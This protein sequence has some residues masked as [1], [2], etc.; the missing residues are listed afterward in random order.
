MNYGALKTLANQYLEVDETTF[1]ANI[2]QFVRLAEEDIFRQVQ[3]Q[4]LMETSTAQVVTGSPYL[5]LPADFLSAYSLAI[6]VGGEYR[7]LLSKDHSFMREVYPNPDV[8]GVPR[9]Y[10]LF[11]DETLMLGPA[12]NDDYSVELNY[13]YEPPSLTEDDDDNNTTWL[14]ENGEQALLFGTLLQGYIYLKGDQDVVA[15]YQNQYQTA[16][17]ALKIIAEGRNR[18]DSYRKSDRRIPV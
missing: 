12:P 15:Q 17:A 18:K 4:E 16:L 3:L 2:G 8:L 11:D 6:M 10:A 13:F 9:F 7:M 5:A 14:S 1:N